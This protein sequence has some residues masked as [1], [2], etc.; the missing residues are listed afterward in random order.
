MSIKYKIIISLILLAFLL[1]VGAGA[2]EGGTLLKGVTAF[3]NVQKGDLAGYI[4]AI[5]KYGVG[6]VAIL[7]V[8]VIMWGG[9]VWLTS[10]GNTGQIDNAKQWISGAVLGL[11]IALT[12]FLI[13][14]TINPQLTNLYITQPIPIDKGQFDRKGRSLCCVVKNT[15][16]IVG[17]KV[18]FGEKC[19]ELSD[20]LRAPNATEAANC[21][22]DVR[23]GSVSVGG[24]CDEDI[25]CDQ[26]CRKTSQLGPDT[27]D[28]LQCIRNSGQL[29][30]TC[31]WTL[32]G[33]S[34]DGCQNASALP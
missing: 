4:A 12:S 10:G 13:L 32:K 1:P 21:V 26:D 19:D 11:I 6:V 3:S 24:K 27:Y 22:V 29:V 25:D 16:A 5:Y 23:P 14:N 8:I 7:A 2:Q 33:Y 30:G 15:G 17:F 18:H 31:E 9:L 34:K 20:G 28:I